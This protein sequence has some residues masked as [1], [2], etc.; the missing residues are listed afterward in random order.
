MKQTIS[1]LVCILWANLV[2]GQSIPK[3]YYDH[4]K[5][6]YSLY[7]AK[8]YKSAANMYSAAFK[9]NGWKGLMDDRYNAACCWALA[10]VPDSAF[11]QL[12]R[13][14]T[15]LNYNDYAHI[16]TD[17][18]LTTLHNDKRWEPLLEK[19]KQ[20]K[21]K[22]EANLNKPL[23]AILDTIYTEDQKYRLQLNEIA[24]K[25]GWDSKEIRD[26]WKI[27]NEKDSINLITVKKILDQYGWLGADV[28]GTQGNSTLFLVIQHSNQATQE[29]YLPIMQ[30]AVKNG[31]A[32]ASD[33]ALLEDRVALAQG[34]RQ[35]YGSQIGRDPDTNLYIVLPL[36]DPENVDKRRASMR[37][38]PLAE[39]V[40]YWQIK[41][42]AAQYK[43][44]LPELEKK[45]SRNR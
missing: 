16:T 19:I 26:Q 7:T 11:F 25:Y 33:L 44:D 13:I 27:I 43:K 35:L 23:V 9:T 18:D 40:S 34:K 17:P 21:D 2:F 3:E 24:K 15:K 42:D 32:D 38:G 28:V 8:N 39:Y 31:K 37:L 30:E 29:K 14:T 6:A 10:G 4:I 12:E 36:E 41:W 20:N 1:I 22:A 5:N 45:L